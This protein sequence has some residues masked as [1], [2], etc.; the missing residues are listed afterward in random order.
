MGLK[1]LTDASTF[2]LTPSQNNIYT[3]TFKIN[4]LQLPYIRHC[5]LTKLNTD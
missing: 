4:I 1:V 5:Q 3:S 2:I